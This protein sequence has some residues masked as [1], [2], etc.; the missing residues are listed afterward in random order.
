LDNTV[1]KELDRICLKALCKRA[2]DRYSTALD[3]AA[4]L[5]HW[6]AG[7]RESPAATVQTPPLSAPSL[8][9][10]KASDSGQRSLQVVPKGR[11]SFDAEDADFF[12]QLLPGPRDREGLP[13][14]IR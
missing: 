9:A 4:D 14:S 7:Y 10:D 6:Q 13:D 2:S 8:R 1:P 11:R 5:R 3:L 12:L